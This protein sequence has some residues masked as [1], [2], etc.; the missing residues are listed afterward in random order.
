MK[1]LSQIINYI[2][3][4]F[5]IAIVT[6]FGIQLSASAQDADARE[7]FTGGVR[8]GLN[9]SNVWDEEGQD[10][11]ADPKAGF[12]GGVFVGIPI[13]K[14]LGVQPELLISQKGFRASGTI[15]G[16]TYSYTKTTT[17]LDVPLQV[18]LKP[19]PFVTILAGPQFSFLLVENNRYTFNGDTSE[20]E[21]EFENDNVRRN[22]LGFVGGVDLNM[23]HFVVSGRACWDL[24]NNKGDGTSSTPRY[25]NQWVQLTVGFKI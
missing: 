19:S 3:S 17:F 9:Y 22:I 16:N 15:V 18:Q 4:K 1:T 11:T 6:I 12:A 2:M 10:F 23:S 21:E 5:L 13:G 8:A 24:Q 25:R 20:Q 7:S 14:F